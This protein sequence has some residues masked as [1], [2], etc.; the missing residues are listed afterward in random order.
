MIKMLDDP[1]LLNRQFTSVAFEKMLNIKLDDYGYRFY[2]GPDERKAPL[3]KLR[4]EFLQNET[5]ASEQP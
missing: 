4:G 2:M 3:E 5:A 1:F